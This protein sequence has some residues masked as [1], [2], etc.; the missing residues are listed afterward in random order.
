MDERLETSVCYRHPDR[1]TRLRCSECGRPICVECSHDA[2]VGQKCPECAK[3]EGRHRV[4]D[5]RRATAAPGFATAPVTFTIIAV[6]AAIFAVGFVT[7]RLNA[8]LVNQF[9]SANWLIADGEWWRVL[10]A[11]FLHGGLAHIF[12]NMYALYIFGPRLET[13]VGSTPFALLYAASAAGGG[14][15][16]YFFGSLQQV[17]VGASGAIFGLFGAWIYV[18]YRIRHTPAGRSMFNQLGVLL[19]INMALP[20]IIRNIDWRAHV[21]GLL[22]GM[23]VAALWGR[24]AVG[25]PDAVRI[26]SIIAGAMFAGL[27][28]LVI[29]L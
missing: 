21:G 9:A 5:A 3:P 25:R 11:A 23:A 24:F 27:M 17:A 28:A 19:L 10:T 12:F 4:I 8:D 29:F 14:V 20:L 15:A 26:R 2:A 1:A 22:A 7:P 6:A 16:S 13:Q 18:A